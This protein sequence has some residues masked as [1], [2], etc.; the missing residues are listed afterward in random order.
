M[1]AGP[2]SLLLGRVA[3][4]AGALA[5]SAILTGGYML[6]LPG[7]PSSEML[8]ENDFKAAKYHAF[9]LPPML[10]SSSGWFLFALLD[11]PTT[12]LFAT[13]WKC[14]IVAYGLLLMYRCA[15]SGEAH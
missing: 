1:S 14:S 7:G 13:G 4:P 11:L 2:L 8:S 10:L 12:Y 9:T 15:V 5:L 3:Y 6:T